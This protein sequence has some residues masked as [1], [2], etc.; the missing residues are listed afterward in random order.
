MQETLV[1]SLGQEI[2]WKRDRLPTAVLLGFCSGSD[3]KESACN[4][5]DLGL[6]PGLGRSPEGGHGNPLQYSCLKNPHGQRSLT[7]YGIGV[8]KRIGHDL[9]TKQQQHVM[10]TLTPS[11]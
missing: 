1:Q 9:E 7:S 4:T 10:H 8:T 11:S 2:P 5:G 6:I 3:G